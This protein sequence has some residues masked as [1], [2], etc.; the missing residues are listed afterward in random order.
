[1][2][3]FAFVL[4]TRAQNNYGNDFKTR[5]LGELTVL[6]CVPSSA[7][8]SGCLSLLVSLDFST[9]LA[10]G[11]GLFG[12]VFTCLPIHSC[13]FVWLVMSGSLDVSSLVS[14]HVSPTLPSSVR[15]FGCLLLRALTCLSSCASGHV[16]PNFPKLS[17]I[18]GLPGDV[19]FFRLFAFVCLPSFVSHLLSRI[20]S[21]S[22]VICLQSYVRLSGGVL[23]CFHHDFIRVS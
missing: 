17:P 4:L 15:L 12:S 5:L 6:R 11:V 18:I 16:S 10:G 23:F 21:V 20:S 2:H 1:M 13:L 9:S 8:V 7:R 19:R 14:L 22:E 3:I